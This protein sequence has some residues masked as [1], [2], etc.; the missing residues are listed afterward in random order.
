MTAPPCRCQLQRRKC[1]SDRGRGWR[2]NV[3]M[4]VDAPQG[5][6]GVDFE[7]PFLLARRDVP[8]DVK[9][10]SSR[11][12][13]H[14]QGLLLTSRDRIARPCLNRDIKY[15]PVICN[16]AM[17]RSHRPPINGSDKER[18]VGSDG[19]EAGCIW[20]EFD[21]GHRCS[22]GQKKYRCGYEWSSNVWTRLW[23]LSIANKC[24]S[25]SRDPE[26]RKLPKR[27]LHQIFKPTRVI[28]GQNVSVMRLDGDNLFKR[29]HIKNPCPRQLQLASLTS[30][31]P[32]D[33]L[34]PDISRTGGS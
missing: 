21:R 14:R 4:D 26:A 17:Q 9:Y 1:L 33:R 19:E 24:T 32:N 13:P 15:R 22:V 28:N 29:W 5:R 3:A 11:H 31:F 12:Q 16:A 23:F 18:L 8:Q 2:V 20:G 7:G 10:D 25:R 34:R 27:Q 30:S 6:I